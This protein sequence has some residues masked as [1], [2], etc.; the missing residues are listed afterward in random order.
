MKIQCSKLNLNKRTRNIR[1]FI[2]AS[3][4]LGYSWGKGEGKVIEAWADDLWRIK[5]YNGILVAK[6]S[7]KIVGALSYYFCGKPQRKLDY[8][9]VDYIHVDKSYRNMGVG[10]SLMKHFEK[11]CRSA[12]SIKSIGL[13]SINCTEYFYESLGYKKSRG[14]FT[15]RIRK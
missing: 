2:S 8:A 11:V 12:K 9:E 13:E 10:T 5:K 1:D 15:K 6:V 14:G 4:C 3:R 7:G